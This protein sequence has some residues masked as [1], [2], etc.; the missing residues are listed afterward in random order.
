MDVSILKSLLCNSVNSI[1]YLEEVDSTNNYAKRLAFENIDDQLPYLITTNDQTKGKGRMG[2]VWKSEPGE[3]IAMSLLLKAP[4]SFSNYS[5]TTLLSALAVV[6]AIRDIASL[7]CLIKWPNDVIY[8]TKKICGILTEMISI[9]NSNYIIV[10]IGINTNSNLFPE[11][12]KD[13][14]TSL[15][16]ATGKIISREEL[17]AKTIN[18]F[19]DYYNDLIKINDLSFIKDEYNSLLISKDKEVILSSDNIPFPENPYI[20]RG[21]D[22]IGGLLV[23]SKNGQTFSVTSGEVSVRGILGYAK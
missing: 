11:E 19:M 1:K 10:G 14:A 12:I 18:Y 5:S 22:S 13:K 9:G 2:R 7:S 17:I 23:E 8:D 15:Y 6:K 4:H 21:I 16:I 20:S 3:N